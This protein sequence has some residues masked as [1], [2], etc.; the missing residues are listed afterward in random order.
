MP[1]Q[2]TSHPSPAIKEKP[3]SPASAASFPLGYFKA[4]C[5]IRYSPV[6]RE[7]PP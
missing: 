6:R 7:A 1:L 3:Q 4:Y 5:V 2:R